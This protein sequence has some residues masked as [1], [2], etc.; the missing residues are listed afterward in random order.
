MDSTTYA[1][2]YHAEM[3]GLLRIALGLDEE[4]GLPCAAR[5]PR[6]HPTLLTIE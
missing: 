5:F 6:E 1:E 2:S 4:S 3:F